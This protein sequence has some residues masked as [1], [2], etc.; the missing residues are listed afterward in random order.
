MDEI[1]AEAL[2]NLNTTVNSL[3]ATLSPAP[4][5]EVLPTKITPTGLG[6]YV[7]EHEDPIGDLFGRRVEA[8]VLVTVSGS[9]NNVL[10]NRALAVRNAIL[11]LSRAER[12]Q[13][14]IHRATP[15]LDIAPATQ[16][17]R[18]NLGFNIVYEFIK[19]PEDAEGIIQ[20]IPLNLELG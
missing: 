2:T 8:Q 18:R 17:N 9:N 3:F 7:G 19:V 12:V 16:A 10:N 15:D 13:K 1:S 14:G 20:E 4:E 11:S 5:V 6:G